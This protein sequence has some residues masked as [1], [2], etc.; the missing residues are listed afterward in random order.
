MRVMETLPKDVI[1]HIWSFVPC[2]STTWASIPRVCKAWY[3]LRMHKDPLEDRPA[4]R[5]RLCPSRDCSAEKTMLRM[6]LYRDTSLLNHVWQDESV[7]VS[8][9]ASSSWFTEWLLS[10]SDVSR[11]QHVLTSAA[12]PDTFRPDELMRR[13]CRAGRTNLVAWLLD[14][15][16]VHVTIHDFIEACRCLENRQ[17]SGPLMRLFCEPHVG[18]WVRGTVLVD[19]LTSRHYHKVLRWLLH[20]EPD[21]ASEEV[22]YRLFLYGMTSHPDVPAYC[23]NRLVY[24]VVRQ[25]HCPWHRIK[26][27]HVVTAAELGWTRI[28]HILLQHVRDM[29]DSGTPRGRLLMSTMQK[30]AANGHA[31]CLHACFQ[32]VHQHGMH[33][34]IDYAQLFRDV[35]RQAPRQRAAETCRVLLDT[36]YLPLDAPGD[37]Y[38]TRTNIWLCTISNGHWDVLKAMLCHPRA[39]PFQ[40]GHDLIRVLMSACPPEGQTVT[41]KARQ[42]VAKVI[43]AMMRRKD[44]VTTPDTMLRIILYARH[45]GYQPLIDTLFHSSHVSSLLRHMICTPLH[46]KDTPAQHVLRK[47]RMPPVLTNPAKS[48]EFDKTLVNVHKKPCL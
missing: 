40:S 12:L 9:L 32:Y 20:W 29:D 18:E 7:D 43:D 15:E 36:D 13:A 24:D 19:C 25:R 35:L 10:M 28:A 23:K 34:H 14:T 38:A 27:D 37:V 3:R 30:A 4:K 17:T 5:A 46:K 31:T 47:R 26:V 42:H 11:I 45:V 2:D 41:F 1:Q 22:L 21:F 48:K 8:I 16:R 39:K 44:F 6:L 33:H